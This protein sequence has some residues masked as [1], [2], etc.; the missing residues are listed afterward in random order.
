M[1]PDMKCIK[2][3]L[4][5]IFSVVGKNSPYKLD[6]FVRVLLDAVEHN[7]FTNNT[8]VRVGGPTGETVFSR[9]KDASFDKIKTAFYVILDKIFFHL[10]RM[11]RNRKVGLCFDTTDEPFYGKVE[12]FWIHAYQP[13]RGSTGCFK[14]ITLSCTDGNTK[15]ILGSLPVPIGANIAAMVKEL[16]ERAKHYVHVDIAL[17]D[18]GFD[19]YRL[20]ETLQKL[21]I[22]HQI[23]W[24]KH[25]WTTHIFNKMKNGEIKEVNRQGIYSRDKTKYE[26]LAKFVLI[27]RYKRNKKSKA[28]NWV[29]CTNTRQKSQ[30]HYVDKYRKRWNIE[31]TFRVLDNIQIKTTTKNEI[32]RYFINMFC[33]LIYNLWKLQNIINNPFYITLKNFVANTISKL[34]KNNFQILDG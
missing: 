6:D 2:K 24:C 15:F 29:F 5:K 32:I 30:H 18:R 27:K 26:V 11:L 8:C 23:L 4:N 7:D 9:L 17:F 16:L 13:V 12:G 1:K 3:F 19:D 10:K 28:Y 14:Y 22:R 31:T 25:K 20:I 33:C 34:I 21:S